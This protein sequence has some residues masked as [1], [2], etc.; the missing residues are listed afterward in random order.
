L[1]SLTD[2]PERFDSGSSLWL[3]GEKRTIEH[4]HW[5]R[6]TPIVQLRGIDSPETAAVLRG[7]LV[8][9]PEAELHAL[10]DDEY[11]QHDLIGLSVRTTG[12]IEIGRVTALLPTGANDVLVVEGE[13]GQY[14]LPLIQDVVLEVDLAGGAVTVDLLEGL[15]P[16]LQ[17]SAAGRRSL[18]RPQRPPATAR[19]T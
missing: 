16:R 7:R 17:R 8:E 5:R 15:D 6:G 13:A 9:L 12:D 2:F 11:Y 3:E 4:S 14:L 19:R 1:E 10:A 18:S